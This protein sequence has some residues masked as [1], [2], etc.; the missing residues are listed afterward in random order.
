MNLAYQSH[1]SLRSIL[2]IPSYLSLDLPRV[3]FLTC[4]PP[5]T[6]HVFLISPIRAKSAAHLILLDVI[7]PVIFVQQYSRTNR[8]IPCT[9][10]PFTVTPT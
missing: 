5:K 7:T 2:V 9:A 1:I 4:F 6:L 3:L 10:V 8:D